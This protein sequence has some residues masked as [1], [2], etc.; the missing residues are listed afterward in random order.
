LRAAVPARS[1]KMLCDPPANTASVLAA[2]ADRLE[3]R[4]AIVAPE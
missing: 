3:Y 4:D 2:A 1:V